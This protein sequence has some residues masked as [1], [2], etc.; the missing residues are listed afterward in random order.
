MGSIAGQT[1]GTKK[2]VSMRLNLKLVD[3]VKKLLK[4][5]DRTEAVE[6]ALQ[7]VAEKERFRRY[8]EK[9]SG[10]FALKGLP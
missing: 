5:K 9:T 2:M 1:S 8:I 3:A 6:R 10:R 7:E 4:A